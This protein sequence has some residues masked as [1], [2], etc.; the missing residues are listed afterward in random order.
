MDSFTWGSVI[1]FTYW[2]WLGTTV[3]AEEAFLTV[4]LRTEYKMVGSVQK[5]RAIK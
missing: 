2:T 5:Q 3:M 1:I 4:D